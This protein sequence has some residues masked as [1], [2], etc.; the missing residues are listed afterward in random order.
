MAGSTEP[1][2]PRP[3]ALCASLVALALSL[4]ACGGS[5]GGGAVA[6]A[7][8]PTPTPSPTASATPT[9]TPTP[10][11]TPT[12]A[13]TTTTATE[14]AAQLVPGWNLGNSLESLSGGTTPATTSQ[15]TAYG[16]PVV[17]QALLN[18]VAAAG[19]KSVRIPVSWLQYADADNGIPSFWLDRVQQVVD[20][21]RNAGLYVII[22]VHYDGGW[23]QPTYAAQAGADARLTKFWQQIAIRFQGY[24]NHLLFAGTNEVMV[25]NQYGAPSAE[26]C[27][28]QNGFNQQFVN[29]VRGTGGGNATRY[30]LVQGYNTNIDYTVSCNAT[31]PTDTGANLLM[32]E[33]HFYDPY[34]FTLN[35]Q[36]AAWQWGA[37]TTD[38]SA[39]AA[40]NAQN[41]S[42]VDAQFAKMQTTFVAKGI[43]VVLGEYGAITKTEYDPSGT[44]RTAWDRY[45]TN[46]AVSHGVV[47]MIWDNGDTTN[48]GLGL[49]NRGSAT[50][51]YQ[52]T[53]NAV[54]GAAK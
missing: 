50:V 4:A 32:M 12:P 35:A 17:T 26:N 29:A 25:T 34:D 37:G 15:E 23:L 41:E 44:Y 30:L 22:N 16:N 47:P 45:V 42:Y 2:V 1:G 31:L 21:A 43:P 7:A 39:T 40:G 53:L 6:V 38:A 54:I 20:Y 3:R 11:S 14:F 27:T 13:P 51:A 28:V 52:A 48:H 19:F 46:S 24:D 9:P 5:D 18:A 10:T 49:F 33:V 8:S 36:S